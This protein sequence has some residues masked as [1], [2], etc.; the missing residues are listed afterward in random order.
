MSG[1]SQKKPSHTPG[2]LVVLD[3]AVW[4]ILPN[5]EPGIP[6]LR[7]DR[8]LHRRWGRKPEAEE[9]S[10]L[11]RLAAAAPTLAEFAKSFLQYDR[12]LRTYSGPLSTLCAGDCETIDKAYDALVGQ[13]H[14]VLAAARIGN[15]QS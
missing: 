11:L 15:T 12:L 6:L 10:A 8:G 5:D 2:P 1:E 4:D 3:D 9:V 13:A 14:D 7:A